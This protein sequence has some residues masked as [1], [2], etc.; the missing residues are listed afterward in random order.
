LTIY[1]KGAYYSEKHKTKHTSPQDRKNKKWATFTYISPQIRKITNLFRNTNLRITYKCRN[2]LANR[3]KPPR[4]HTPPHNQWGIYQLTCNT[5]NLSYV[6]QTSRSLNI[7]YKE[8]IHYIRSNNPQSAYALHILQNRHEY[9]PIDNT[10]TLLK[11]IKNYR[12]MCFIVNT[13]SVL[14]LLLSYENSYVHSWLFLIY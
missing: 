14:C 5:C 8:H 9:G 7:R 12:V 10:M 1:Q 6:G 3:I 13:Q 4:D 2:T 11:H